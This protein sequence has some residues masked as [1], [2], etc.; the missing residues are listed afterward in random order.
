M[1]RLIRF[2]RS[3]ELAS[4]CALAKTLNIYPPNPDNH[5]LI[6]QMG[7]EHPPVALLAWQNL[8]DEA[9][10]LSI[11]VTQ[12]YQRQGIAFA[13]LSEA[14]KIWR[15]QAIC[16]VLLEV[17]ASNTSAQAFYTHCGFKHIAM[18]NNYYPCAQGRENALI[19]A[20]TY[21][22]QSMGVLLCEVK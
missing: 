19:F 11:G 17:R 22:C 7:D 2:A 14:E 15:R 5:I 20:K 21:N 1:E 16:R 18:R 4:V 3:D 12:S 8:V 13:L 9:E 6:A 10:I